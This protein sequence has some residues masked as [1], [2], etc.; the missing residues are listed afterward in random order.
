MADNFNIY[1]RCS[2]CKGT[3]KVTINDEPYD[4]GP[5]QEIDCGQCGGEGKVLWGEM[6]EQVEE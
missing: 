5:P 3:G 4:P 2:V 6:L 1:Q